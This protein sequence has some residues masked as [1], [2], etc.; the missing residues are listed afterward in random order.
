MALFL[1][2]ITNI[3]YFFLIWFKKAKYF[4]YSWKMRPYLLKSEHHV[5]D[6]IKTI[7]TSIMLNLTFSVQS[8]MYFKYLFQVS[9]GLNKR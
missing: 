6:V 3:T 4:I 5:D 1:L 9:I 2:G 8:V 7:E